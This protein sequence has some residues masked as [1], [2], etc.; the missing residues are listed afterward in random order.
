MGDGQFGE[1]AG[2][3]G[4]GGQVGD[5]F[6]ELLD[7]GFRAELEDGF[8]EHVSFVVD[9]VDFHTVTEGLL[10][11]LGEEGGFGGS[12][13]LSGLEHVHVFDDFDHTLVDLGGDLEGVEER[14]LG[15]VHS[16]ASWG[17]E[18]VDGGHVS[19]L[20]DGFSL[21]GLDDF[22]QVEDGLVGEDETELAAQLGLQDFQL[23]H[24]LAESA[25][26]VVVEDVLVQRSSSHVEGFFDDGHFTNN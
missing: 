10:V 21:V 12:H 1:V 9:A 5:S 18:H 13:D 14:N 16:S 25:E 4:E 20:G 3:Q 22:L 26:E 19:G 23:G 7:K 24:G 6:L 15:W 2:F 8:G 11:H 17:D